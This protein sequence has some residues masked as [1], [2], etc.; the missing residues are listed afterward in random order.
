MKYAVD[1]IE[2]NIV[3]LE[4]IIDGSKKNILLKDIT[5]NIIEGDILMF[6][7]K[8]YIKDDNLKNERLKKIQ[9]KMNRLRKD[10]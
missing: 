3:T 2:D 6:N 1:K 10:I 9:E 5:F 8:K 4:N 7:G